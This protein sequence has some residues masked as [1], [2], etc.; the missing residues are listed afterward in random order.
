MPKELRCSWQS[1]W[2]RKPPEWW[3]TWLNDSDHPVTFSYE[4]QIDGVFP[5]WKATEI[6]PALHVCLFGGWLGIMGARWWW[7]VAWPDHPTTE[8]HGYDPFAPVVDMTAILAAV[9]LE[10]YGETQ[11]A[12]V[13]EL[14]WELYRWL[15]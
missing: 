15:P 12:A 14:T 1:Q 8:L 2:F 11:V 7:R 6:V 5:T 13:P 10:G 9:E 4:V 3:G